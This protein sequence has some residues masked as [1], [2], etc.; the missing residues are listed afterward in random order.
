MSAAHW[1][2]A[3]LLFTALGHTRDAELCRQAASALDLGN[4]N[5]VD[6]SGGA[7]TSAGSGGQAAVQA[8]VRVRLGLQASKLVLYGWA[9]FQLSTDDV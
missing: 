9:T 5:G 8:E 4:G 3:A 2:R 7:G 1:S 6:Q